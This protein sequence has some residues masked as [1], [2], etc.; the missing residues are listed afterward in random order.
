MLIKRSVM[1]RKALFTTM[2]P[3]VNKFRGMQGVNVS[4]VWLELPPGAGVRTS[5]NLMDRM[6]FPSGVV[7]GRKTHCSGELNSTIGPW[8]H[9]VTLNRLVRWNGQWGWV[10]LSLWS[11]AIGCDASHTLWF[12]MKGISK[13]NLWTDER[14]YEEAEITFRKRSL[15]SAFKLCHTFDEIPEESCIA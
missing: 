2:S 15:R 5:L 14:S 1:A 11:L 3:G 7:T 10:E 12:L 9:P 8:R 4:V 6:W 13:T